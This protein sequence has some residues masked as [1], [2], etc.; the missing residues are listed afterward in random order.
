LRSEL[1]LATFKLFHHLGRLLVILA[2]DR[3]AEVAQ[4]AA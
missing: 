1:A 4:A 3:T 2:A